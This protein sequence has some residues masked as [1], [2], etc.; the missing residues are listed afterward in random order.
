VGGIAEC[1]AELGDR[2]EKLDDYFRVHDGYTDKELA[3]VVGVKEKELNHVLA[4]Y[5]RLEL[6]EK[7]QKC[8]EE[9]GECSFEAEL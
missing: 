1:I 3:T 5:A 4:W 6:G 2:K 8:V 7:I 9:K